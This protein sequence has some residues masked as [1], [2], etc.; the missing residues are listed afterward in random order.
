[1]TSRNARNV[2]PG[3]CEPLL[4]KHRLDRRRKPFVGK[5]TDGG[6]RCC[7]TGDVVKA[8]LGTLN[9]PAFTGLFWF[10]KMLAVWFGSLWPN[11]DTIT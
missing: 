6:E 8:A 4:A 3:H 2:G 1:M 9:T 10:T 5:A 11:S 7:E